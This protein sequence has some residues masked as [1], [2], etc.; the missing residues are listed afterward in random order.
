[1]CR[2]IHLVRNLVF[3][4]LLVFILFMNNG[5]F[6]DSRHATD[7]TVLTC[8]RTTGDRK[9]YLQATDRQKITLK[10]RISRQARGGSLI[11][12]RTLFAANHVRI[13][14]I[15]C[16]SP[17]SLAN[18]ANHL[19][20]MRITCESCESLWPINIYSRI[21]HGIHGNFHQ[22]TINHVVGISHQ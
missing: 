18:H 12:N 8:D 13:M 3:L 9:S 10:L 4:A 17:E 19:R 6:S 1:M 16:E 21:L 5:I 2:H 22:I 14:R 11:P 20:I 15:T 7:Y